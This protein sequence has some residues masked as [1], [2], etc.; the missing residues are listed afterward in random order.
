[1]E[2]DRKSPHRWS[3]VLDT[4]AHILSLFIVGC[5]AASEGAGCVTS[6]EFMAC[7]RSVHG[8]DGA[9]VHPVDVACNEHTQGDPICL[10]P[11]SYARC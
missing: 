8:D 5:G 7:V 2:K 10:R 3:T 4:H 6:W 1:M 11:H 9:Y